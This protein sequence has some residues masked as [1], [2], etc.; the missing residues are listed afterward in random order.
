M[1][2]HAELGAH[3]QSLRA[4]LRVAHAA[5]TVDV[6]MTGGIGEQVEDLARPAPRSRARRRRRQ[7]IRSCGA[8]YARRLDPRA[9]VEHRY[10]PRS[11]R[12]RPG[13]VSFRSYPNQ[14]LDATETIAELRAQAA[15]AGEHGFDGVMTSEH[16]G[17]FAGYLPNPLQLAGFLLDAMPHGW[18]APCPLLLPL[19]PGRARRGGD[20]VARGAL[21]RAGSGSG[22]RPAR[23][24]STS[25]SWTCR[26]TASPRG[27]RAGLELVAAALR[28]EAPGRSRPIPRSRAVASIRS[29]C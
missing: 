26:W 22:S 6:V 25:R 18:A 28:G 16:H 13:S 20:G 8:A 14:G 29:P 11:C 21:S 7:W 4:L 17:G 12:S 23:W 15:L 27:S 2:R 9:G 1:H 24:P 3:L 5:G 19:R 10:A